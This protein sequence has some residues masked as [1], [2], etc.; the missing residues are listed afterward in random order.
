MTTPTQPGPKLADG[1]TAE[2]FAWGEDQVLKLYREGWPRRTAEFEHK[3]ALASQQTGYRV[4]QVGEIVEID[5]RAGIVY[6]R[7]EGETMLRGFQKNLLKFPSVVRQL[8]DLHLEMHRCEASGLETIVQRLTDKIG[9]VELLD[10]ETR[11]RILKHLHALPVDNKLLHGDFYPDNIMLTLNGPVIID[12]IDATLGH[13]LADVARTTVLGTFGIPPEDKVGRFMIGRMVS[14][15]LRRYFRFSPF[16]R[17]ELEAWLLPVATG[18]LEENIPH[19]TEPLLG[20]RY[21]PGSQDASGGVDQPHIRQIGFHTA[22]SG[23]EIDQRSGD[24]D[25]TPRDQDQQPHPAATFPTSGAI[26]AQPGSPTAG[27][28][29]LSASGPVI[30]NDS[31]LAIYINWKRIEKTSPCIFGGTLACMIDMNEASIS[32]EEKKTKNNATPNINGLRTIPK[33]ASQ[34]PRKINPSM[35]PWMRGRC[36]PRSSRSRPR[37]RSRRSSPPARSPAASRCPSG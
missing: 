17:K 8:A 34:I 20:R 10:S 5:G 13:P 26:P 35:I 12:W 28:S 36:R 27:S 9:R 24:G 25:Q 16:S 15:Y 18:R 4:P 29:T 23:P 30:S 1:R 11:D 14:G 3:Q 21:P 22:G 33:T 31:G 2:V 37:S 7:V 19:E 32:G 6:Q